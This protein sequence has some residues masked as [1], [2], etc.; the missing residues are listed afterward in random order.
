MELTLEH[1][2]VLELIKFRHIDRE[3][4]NKFTSKALNWSE[5]LGQLVY[6]RV[7]G[8]AH[9]VLM[10]AQISSFNREVE[11]GLYAIYD[12]Q[13][14]R[15]LKLQEFIVELSENLKKSGVPHAFLKGAVLV[16]S[17]Y[18]VGC[19][20]SNDIDILVNT[21]DLT[22]L[23]QVLTGIGYIQGDY[24]K[25]DHSIRPATR[26]EI[27]NHRMNYGE[28]YPYCKLNNSSALPNVEVDL[29]FSLDW[30]AKGGGEKV[31]NFLQSAESYETRDGSS[32]YSL[33]KEYFLIHLCVHLYKEA[34][35]LNWVEWQRDLGLYKFVDIYS[36]LTDMNDELDYEMLKHITR[37]NGLEKECFYALEFTRQL[38]EP[39][40]TDKAF[41]D[42]IQAIKPENT[43]FLDQIIDPKTNRLL[44]WNSSFLSRVFDFKRAEQLNLV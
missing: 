23:N 36:F 6:N 21:D 8:I 35:V 24:Q 34:A 17:I 4:I 16:N 2:L 25:A 27:M 20:I 42:F 32:I 43:A 9:H 39:L 11:M 22:K 30:K 33:K 44:L 28:T 38:F 29:N 19:R 10:E 13:Q 7:A 37:E 5:V 40:N 1:K 14:R 31:F 41:L 26:V 15:T 3:A 12:F 18:P